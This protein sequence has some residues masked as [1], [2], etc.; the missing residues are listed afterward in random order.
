MLYSLLITETSQLLRF[1]CTLRIMKMSKILNACLRLSRYLMILTQFKIRIIFLLS[2]L[3]SNMSLLHNN[4][5]P[6]ACREVSF[7]GMCKH[8]CLGSGA[9]IT[10]CRFVSGATIVRTTLLHLLLRVPS[11]PSRWKVNIGR[12]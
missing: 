6:Q 1:C 10:L 4:R 9:Y 3:T 7:L 12:D 11:L 5:Y 2:K 8:C